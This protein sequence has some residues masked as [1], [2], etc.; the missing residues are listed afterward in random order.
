MMDMFLDYRKEL[1]PMEEYWELMFTKKQMAVIARRSGTKEVHY[2]RLCDE[3]FN[4]TRR[5]HKSTDAHVIWL[6]KTAADTI[7]AE[8]ED[9]TKATYKYLYL[10]DSPYSWE[11]CPDEQKNALLGKSATNDEAESTLGGATKNIQQFN[12][13][14]LSS[15]GAVSAASRNGVF[16]A[17]HQMDERLQE[18]VIRMAMKYAPSTKQRNNADLERQAK[19]R[20]EKEELKKELAVLNAS[21]DLV[22]AAHYCR[23]YHKPACWK[24]D[25]KEVWKNLNAMARDGATK[26]DQMDAVKNNILIRV[27]GF[28]WKEFHHAWSKKGTFYTIEQL[29]A[30]LEFIIEKEKDYEIPTF[31]D[32]A[33]YLPTRRDLPCLGTRTIDVAEL[34]EKAR[35]AGGQ[36]KKDAEV[37]CR[38]KRE[39][40]DGEYYRMLQPC[41]APDPLSL[42]GVRID[43]L[44]NLAPKGCEKKLRWYQGEVTGIKEV[45]RKNTK[46]NKSNVQMVHTILWDPVDDDEFNKAESD[47]ILHIKKWNRKTAMNSWRLDVDVSLEA[48]GEE[49][50]GDVPDIINYNDNE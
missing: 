46:N 14:H 24:G 21:E 16:D 15:A 39:D 13:V 3:L 44:H 41:E 25:P 45:P 47:E 10:S 48:E 18:A 32:H 19:I 37:S 30:H 17:L 5:A 33:A 1:P 26:K 43:M 8:L 11:H 40:R 12:G 29:A 4:P 22:E 42:V 34:D 35:E 49:D 20:R 9:E 2:K 31:P 7:I 36:F 28:N 23:L 27:K 50:E 38:K 6:A